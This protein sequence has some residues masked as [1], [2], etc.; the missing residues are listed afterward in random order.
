MINIITPCYRANNVSLIYKSINFNLINKW[1]IIYD[2]SKDRKYTKQFLDNPQIIEIECSD[3]GIVG[4]SQRNL[5]LKI[6][7]DDFIYF[8]DDDNIIHP[9]FWNIIP[10]LDK[11][12]FYTWDQLRIENGN[13]SPWDLNNNQNG[14]ILYGNE[15]AL[16]KIDTAQYILPRKIIKDIKFEPNI[17][18]ADGLFISKIYELNKDKHIYISKTACYYNKLS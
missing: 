8:L 4:N 17:Y 7:D 14:A 3:N 11:E 6:I 15:V 10:T 5:A 9:E 16:K 2:T 1:Y 12:Y 13:N 18:W